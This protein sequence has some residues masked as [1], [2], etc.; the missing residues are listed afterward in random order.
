MY[1]YL[2]LRINRQTYWTI[3]L[4]IVVLFG[5]A[6]AFLPKPPGIGEVI[7]ITLGVPRLHDLGRSGWWMAVPIGA[8]IVGI[9]AG[10]ALGGFDGILIA[11]GVV[12][13]LMAV[14]MVVIGLIPGQT[15][16]NA[17]G[18]PPPPGF[19]WRKTEPTASVF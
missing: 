1:S 4:P 2:N 5:L 19:G 7:L 16:A 10:I 6:I 13:L 17:F 18:E 14:M 15:E 9:G 3:L 8:E 12:V 11:G